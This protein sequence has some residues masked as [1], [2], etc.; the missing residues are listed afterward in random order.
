MALFAFASCTRIKTI[1]LG[2]GVENFGDYAFFG[3]KL[4]IGRS[5]K[6]IVITVVSYCQN[7]IS[8]YRY[9]PTIDD[10]GMR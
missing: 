7:L 8:V 2:D 5:L 4:V 1:S 9:T 3:T 6:R 10:S